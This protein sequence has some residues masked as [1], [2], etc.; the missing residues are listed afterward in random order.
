MMD[1]RL[2]P[3]MGMGRGLIAPKHSIKNIMAPSWPFCPTSGKG[4]RRVT[5]QDINSRE[6][7]ADMKTSLAKS[8]YNP[9]WLSMILHHF[10]N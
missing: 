4:L 8:G 3:W 2:K 1:F 6:Y 10:L 5:P 7:L 9:F